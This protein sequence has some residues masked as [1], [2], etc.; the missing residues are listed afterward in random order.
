[1]ILGKSINIDV[2]LKD[3]SY[4]KLDQPAFRDNDGQSGL[5]MGGKFSKMEELQRECA[6][7]DVYILSLQEMKGENG[8]SGYW[9]VYAC[10]QK[11]ASKSTALATCR[12]R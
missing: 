3:Y 9:A 8:T 11:T 12:R 4:T 5:A 6:D 7:Y 1:M 2:A 10:R